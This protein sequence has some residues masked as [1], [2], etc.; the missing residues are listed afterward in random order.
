MDD[1]RASGEKSHQEQSRVFCQAA[2]Q[3]I[4]LIL[5]ADGGRKTEKAGR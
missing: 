3:P 5:G 4:M 2:I 1:Y